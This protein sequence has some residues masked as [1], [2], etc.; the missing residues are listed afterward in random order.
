MEMS[1]YPP[2]AQ[3]ATGPAS[4]FHNEKLLNSFIEYDPYAIGSFRDMHYIVAD[5]SIF[6]RGE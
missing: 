3:V 2:P 6:A 5:Q 1:G 4:L